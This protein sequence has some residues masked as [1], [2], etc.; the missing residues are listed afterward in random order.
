MATGG[1][2]LSAVAAVTAV[3]GRGGAVTRPAGR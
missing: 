3:T 1:H 2:A